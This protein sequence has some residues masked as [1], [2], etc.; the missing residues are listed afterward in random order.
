MYHRQI[1]LP[2]PPEDS[3]FL[4]GPRQT[5][6]STLLKNTYPDAIWIDLLKADEFRRY[7]QHPERLREELSALTDRPFI[8]IDEIQK[9]PALL[10]E[11]HWLI[12]NQQLHFALCGSSARKVKRGHANLLG[13]RAIRYELQGLV[14]AELGEN[15]DLNRILNHGYLPSHYDKSKPNRHIQA[16][17]S[18][19]LKE[20]IAAEGLV[21][22]LPAFA[23]F[24]DAVALT[25]CEIVNYANIASDCGVSNNTVKEYFQILQDTLLGSILNAYKKRPK[26]KVSQT[27]KFYFND[28]GIVNFLAKRKTLQPGS[29]LYGKALENWVFHELKC[30]SQ[31]REIFYELSYWRLST[32]AEVD[33]IVGDMEV[34][35]EVKASSNIKNVHLKGL[36][37]L[38]KD[39]PQVKQR[40]IVCL[41][42][43]ERITEDNIHIMPAT[44]FCQ[45]LWDGKIHR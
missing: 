4:W 33:F 39:Q 37:E 10:D 23:H 34:A 38:I 7:T 30:H 26:R 27:P 21:R 45:K 18:E 8:V 41:E 40:I 36:R 44:V 28:I 32:G 20:E 9:V 43:L 31:Y 35:I 3:F 14:S 16:Y 11:V 22:N 24:L 1:K 15:F 17:V 25:D 29:E 5:G 13:G 42:T 19:Y 2:L 6:K 12:E